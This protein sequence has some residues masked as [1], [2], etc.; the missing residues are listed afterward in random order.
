MKSEMEILLEAS[1]ALIEN[2]KAARVVAEA[3]CL[4]F[5]IDKQV[6]GAVEFN[7]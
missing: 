5:P 2:R 4:K 6:Q 7:Q 1:I 3:K